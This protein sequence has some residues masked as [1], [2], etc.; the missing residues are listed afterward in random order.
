MYLRYGWVYIVGIFMP[1]NIKKIL[2]IRTGCSDPFDPATNLHALLSTKDSSGYSWMMNFPHVQLPQSRQQSCGH[3]FSNRK[4]RFHPRPT[5]LRNHSS[6]PCQTCPPYLMPGILH[7]ETES[8]PETEPWRRPFS[9]FILNFF[10]CN[11]NVFE[12]F[13]RPIIA[14]Y[15]YNWA[16]FSSYLNISMTWNISF[17]RHLS[18][19]C[20]F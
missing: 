4:V 12:H 18:L 3:Y 5:T 10:I 19:S 6:V 7:Y 13:F 16:V 15:H 11:T 8:L 2:Y 1:I 20:Y 14:L 9:M 17:H